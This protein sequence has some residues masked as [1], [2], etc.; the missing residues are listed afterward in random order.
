VNSHGCP[1]P[2]SPARFTRPGRSLVRHKRENAAAGASCSAAVSCAGPGLFI[3]RFEG[4]HSR[5][6]AEALVDH[7]L[8]VSAEESPSLAEVEFHLLDL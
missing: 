6:A 8:L 2:I 5:E 1:A 3:V 7:D 4:I